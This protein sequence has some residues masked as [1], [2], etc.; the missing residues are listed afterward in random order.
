MTSTPGMPLSPRQVQALT[1]AA[2][3]ATLSEI[4]RQLG[5]TREQ[6]SYLL[7][8]AYRRLDVGHLPR[9]QKRAAAVRQAVR[10]GIIPDPTET[11]P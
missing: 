7:S 1:A 8:H 4:G 2:T 9:D 10:R 5:V 11:T 3:G 6:V